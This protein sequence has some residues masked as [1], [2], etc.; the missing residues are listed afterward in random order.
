[1]HQVK[2]KYPYLLLALLLGFLSVEVSAQDRCGTVPYNKQLHPSQSTQQ[3]EIHF[4]QWIDQKLRLK[5]STNRTKA[6]PYKI[7]VVVHIIH[8]GEPIGSGTNIPVAQ[9]LSQIKVLNEDYRR[10]NADASNTPPEFAAIAGSLDIEFVLAKRNPEGQTTTGIT[11]TRGSK[12]A[13]TMN[14]NYQ[15]K[16]QSYWPA[17]NYLNIWVCNLTDNLGY[18]QFPVSDLPGMETSSTN[19]LTDGVVITYEA[20]G[21]DDDGNF[22]LDPDYNKGRTATHEIGHFFGLNHIW[23]DD[24]G[25]AGTDNVTDTPNQANFTSGCPAHPRSTCNPAVVSMFQ[26]F[27]DYTDDRCMNLFTEGQVARMKV[28]IENSPRRKSLLTSPGLLPPDPVNNDLGIRK[29]I[30]PLASQCDTDA[31]PSVQLK[32]YG[33]NNVTTAR[34]RLRVN[35]NIVE[36]KDYTLNLQPQDSI[37]VAFSN[38]V[39]NP[40]INTVT[41]DVVLTN[42]VTDGSSTGNNNTISA[43]VFVPPAI[44]LPFTVLFNTLPGDWRIENPDQQQTWE[45][46]NAPYFQTNNKAL[47]L[48]FFDYE[49]NIGEQDILYSPVFDLSDAQSPSLFFDVSYA[50]YDEDYD[51]LSV[52]VITNCAGISSGVNVYKRSSSQLATSDPTDSYYIPNDAKDWRKEFIDLSQFAGER[53]VQLAFVAINNFGNNLYLDNISVVTTAFVDLSLNGIESPSLVTCNSNADIVIT[54]QN[55]GTETIQSVLLEYQLN[56]GATQRQ[57]FA[58]LNLL[59]G[60]EKPISIPGIDLLEGENNIT[61]SVIEVNNVTDQ[62]TENNTRDFKVV[63]NNSVDRIPLRQNFDRPFDAWTI[64]NPATGMNWNAI[65]TNY[66]QSL[67][68]QAFDNTNAGDQ[69]WLVSPVLDFTHVTEASMVFD[70]SY[71]TRN[72]RM[73]NLRVLVSKNCGNTYEELDFEFPETETSTSSW[74]PQNDEDW[75]KDIYIN[76]STYAGQENVR[77]AFVVTNANGNN[78]YLDNIEFFV[79]ETPTEVEIEEPFNVFGYSATNLAESDLKIGFN[80]EEREVVKC[81]IIDLMGKRIAS[82]VWED[83]LNQ[84]FELPSLETE[85]TGVYIVKLQIGNRQ[86][87][88]RILVGRE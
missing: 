1:M 86:Y 15:L 66:D 42:G 7:P 30:S 19:R 45:L 41:I 10:E 55:A 81:E 11:R 43:T 17:E 83:V 72:E 29:I 23:G 22:D 5:G 48:P 28:V 34:L 62:N 12:N 82:V 14:D 25:C 52:M 54:T 67:Y 4:K 56:N 50:Q 71:A 77:V 31:T 58:A 79:T 68:F 60:E 13:W 36:T 37:T 85:S 26:N 40:D 70:L 69:S 47:V 2:S 59:S 78:L 84:V 32:N 16:S 63:V 65:K 76:L 27:L 80:L 64:A 38:I 51:S 46:G 20:F 49:D 57:S 3:R 88:E 35:G 53:Y 24:N 61:V 44:E 18:A 8:N 75:F 73:E 21:S 87:A 33:K 6:E 74:T 39:L 9:V